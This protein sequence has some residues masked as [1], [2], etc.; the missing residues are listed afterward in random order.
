MSRVTSH[1][2]K[3]EKNTTCPSGRQEKRMTIIRGM[4]EEASPSL[5]L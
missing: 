1:H 4:N 5:V 2:Q 3:E